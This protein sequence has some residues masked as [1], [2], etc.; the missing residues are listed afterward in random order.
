MNHHTIFF[1]ISLINV[2]IS[3]LCAGAVLFSNDGNTIDALLCI[4]RYVVYSQ[5]TLIIVASI[6]VVVSYLR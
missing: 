1:V 5:L 3:A 4:Q 6:V 2:I